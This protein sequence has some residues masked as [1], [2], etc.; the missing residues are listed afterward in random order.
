M[1]H[2]STIIAQLLKLMPRHEFEA[3]ARHF[4]KGRDL[5]PDPIAPTPTH[6]ETRMS[7]WDSNVDI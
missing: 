7:L 3:L 5:R 2:H 1:A 6:P 4:H